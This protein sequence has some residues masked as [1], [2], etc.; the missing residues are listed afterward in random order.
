MIH[1]LMAHPGHH[2]DPATLSPI[3]PFFC[4]VLRLPWR[5]QAASAPCPGAGADTAR[6]ACCPHCVPVI[7][8]DHP[9][10]K[11]RH[12]EPCN[13]GCND[14]APREYDEHLCAEADAHGKADPYYCTVPAHHYPDDAVPVLGDRMLSE[15]RAEH[16]ARRRARQ[17]ADMMHA[18]YA[19]AVDRLRRDAG[20]P[21]AEE[22]R[23]EY[24]RLPQRKP[25]VNRQP[26]QTAE[27][28]VYGQAPV[29]DVLAAEQ[30]RG[31]A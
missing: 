26:W 16:D 18:G 31:A 9:E 15:V 23:A 13:F 21:T 25:M 24:F 28:P 30:E 29:A 19:R 11:D 1:L 27:Q 10:D 6:Y 12:P 3:P 20:L 7:P 8:G 17:Y 2:F 5:K 14:P 4:R 22:M